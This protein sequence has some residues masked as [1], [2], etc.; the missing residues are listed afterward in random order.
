MRLSMKRIFQRL[1][2]YC[3]HYL[4]AGRQRNGPNVVFRRHARLFALTDCQ[5]KA[6]IL[7]IQYDFIYF[8]QAPH[9][10]GNVSLRRRSTNQ[11]KHTVWMG[12]F[13]PGFLA[14]PHIA[15][16][17]SATRRAWTDARI[18][19][20]LFLMGLTGLLKC[21]MVRLM[22]QR[23]PRLNSLSA[24]RKARRLFFR[25]THTLLFS[26]SLTEDINVK[27]KQQLEKLLPIRCFL[28]TKSWLFLQ[29]TCCP[30]A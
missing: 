2:E 8:S 30:A 20:P 21:L 29:I 1:L 13:I 3:K 10:G 7:L 12:R 16:I 4:H 22:G 17:Y 5:A 18:T 11:G 25:L 23:P 15:D 26:K 28:A 19:R 24:R 14:V 27:L 6:N 9:Q